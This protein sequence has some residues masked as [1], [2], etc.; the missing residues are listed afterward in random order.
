MEVQISKGKNGNIEEIRKLAKEAGSE[1]DEIEEF[2]DRDEI[3]TAENKGRFM[4]FISYNKEESSLKISELGVLEKFRGKEVGSELLEEVME[5]AEVSDAENIIVET[6]NDNIPALSLYQK[7]EFKIK[8][9][10]EGKL[11]EHHEGELK[12]WEGIPVRDLIILKKSLD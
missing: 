10:K 1:E 8:E 2:L 5:L 3:L 12:G 11:M 7:K 4:G 6:S 9:V